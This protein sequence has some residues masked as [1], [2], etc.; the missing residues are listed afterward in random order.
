MA[1]LYAT[2][3]PHRKGAHVPDLSKYLRVCR[4]GGLLVW[5]MRKYIPARPVLA[6]VFMALGAHAAYL[7]NNGA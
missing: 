4:R 2:I 5:H 7:F 3:D 1:V 6:L